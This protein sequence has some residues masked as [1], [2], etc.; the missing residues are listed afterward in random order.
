MT[1]SGADGYV[2][3]DKKDLASDKFL[4]NIKKIGMFTN[5]YVHMTFIVST[6]DTVIRLD[7]TSTHY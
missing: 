7:S 4:I 3:F 5:Q 2:K 6:A 1:S